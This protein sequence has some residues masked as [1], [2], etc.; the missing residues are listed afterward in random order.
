ML[1]ALQRRGQLEVE[2]HPRECLMV[3]CNNNKTRAQHG[4]RKHSRGDDVILVE[5]EAH[6][7]RCEDRAA[8]SFRKKK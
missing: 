7:H 3:S 8:I 6:R 4:G 1:T 2:S 5:E